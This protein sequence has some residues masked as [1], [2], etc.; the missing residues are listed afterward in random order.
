M[1]NFMN[2]DELGLSTVKDSSAFKK[3]QFFSKTNTESIYN[4]KSDFESN[5]Y[6]MSSLYNTDLR[7]MS[8]LSYGISRQHNYNSLMSSNRTPLTALDKNSVD[9]FFTYNLNTEQFN[10]PLDDNSH[11]TTYKR[12]NPSPSNTTNTLNSFFGDSLGSSH[13]TFNTNIA[14][15]TLDSFVGLE[16]DS[17]QSTNTFKY[18]SNSI[19]KKKKLMYKEWLQP[20][21][22]M[23]SD[24]STLNPLSRFTSELFNKELVP[25]FKNLKSDDLQLLSSE[26]NPRLLGNYNSSAY[27]H[28]FSKH[29]NNLTSANENYQTS[30]V[31]TNQNNMYNLSQLNWPDLN[32]AAKISNN[33]VWMPISHAPIMSSNPNVHSTS[34][35]FFGKNEDD[36]TPHML[37]SKD[38][39]APN[40]IFNTY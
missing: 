31:G 22:S 24:L 12:D 2:F 33:T 8:S 38:E 16:T 35:D 6:R 26:R 20:N 27:T 39:S 14:Y 36:L 29:E 1:L 25:K 18:S 30:N 23:K 13:R 5:Y 10:A 15:P 3:I 37:R 19:L 28:N 4:L 32:H 11:I 9:K 40:H 21:L 17:K 34:Y 7:L